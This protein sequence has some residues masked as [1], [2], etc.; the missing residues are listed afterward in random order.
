MNMRLSAIAVFAIGCCGFAQSTEAAL[1]EHEIDQEH[2]AVIFK[3][4]NRGVSYVF[5]RFN[6]ISGTVSLDR[7]TKPKKLEF[8]VELKAGSI[9]TNHKKRDRELS[10]KK[11][12]DTSKHRKIT[13]KSKACK[14]LEEEGM[15]EITGDLT[16]LGTTKELTVVFHLIGTDRKSSSQNRIGGEATFTVKRSDFGM[17]NM[18][19]SIDDEVTLMV[20]IEAVSKMLPVG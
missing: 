15:Y 19:E 1:V 5:G 3:V 6:G 7:P 18:L 17:T 4:K 13:F 20:N 10:G 8:F 2:S 14:R 12:F 11:F 16:L 9:D